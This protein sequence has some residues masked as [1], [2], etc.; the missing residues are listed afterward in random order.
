MNRLR[1]LATIAL[2]L[3]TVTAGQATVFS[4]R[5]GVSSYVWERS[6]VDSTDTR[7]V[8]N[9]GTASLRLARIGG[10]DIEVSTSLRGRYDLRNAGDN[11]DDYHV[12]SLQC[13]WRD[14]AQV[15]DLT[16]G[17]HFVSWPVSP[18][19]IDGA[20][21]SVHPGHGFAL[22]GYAG[23][24]VPDDGR[25]RV[26]TA[27]EGQALGVQLGYRARAVGSMSVFFAQHDRARLYGTFAVDNLAYRTL[28][29]DWRRPVARFGSLY[30]QFTYEMP[31]Q[32]MSRLHLSARWQA[33]PNVA[34][35]GQFRYRRPD[36]PYNSIFWVFGDAR[37]Y[38]WRLRTNIRLN[39]V[40]SVTAGGAYVDLVAG[41]VL[42]YDLG[43]TH[44]YFNLTLHAQSGRTGST[45]GVS[46]EAQYPISHRWTLHGGSRFDSYELIE[47]QADA[48]TATAWWAGA[49]WD[50]VPQSTLELEAQLVTQDLNTERL[51][52]GDKSDVR[53][54]ARI[55]WWFF[56]RL[57]G[58]EQTRLP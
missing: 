15:V 22:S 48:N 34:L 1:I 50:W 45:F 24:S 13:R 39:D 43:A 55:S 12:Y 54:L 49:R 42:R 8:Q 18:V 51:F 47:D 6:E 11:L 17:R 56:R 53:L 40:W 7:H 29:L 23:V 57:D 32:R 10:R 3:T 35:N 27:A 5:L 21:L 31:T 4:G 36:L 33:S 26:Q 16:V 2:V 19:S 58:M 37:Y 25:L 44:R 20:S 30:G 28:G 9:V 41:H 14:L 46:G 52:A 38:D